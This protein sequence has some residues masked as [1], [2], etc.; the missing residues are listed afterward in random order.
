[1]KIDEFKELCLS[2]G[3]LKDALRVSFD[4]LNMFCIRCK[5][6]SGKIV[7]YWLVEEEMTEEMALK[8]AYECVVGG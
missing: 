3:I 4:D 6:S 1:M 5:S 2:Y 8:M 7:G